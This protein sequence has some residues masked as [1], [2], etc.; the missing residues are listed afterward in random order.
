MIGRNIRSSSC[1]TSGVGTASW[2]SA[3]GSQ[4]GIAFSLFFLFFLLFSF[5]GIRLL[6]AKRADRKEER[7][8]KKNIYS[9]IPFFSFFF[10]PLQYSTSTPNLRNQG[11]EQT[12][13]GE[14]NTAG[15][16]G[17]RVKNENSTKMPKPYH[18]ERKRKNR[19]QTK[20]NQ[21]KP[22]QTSNK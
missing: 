7:K 6:T 17:A 11:D 3:V 9:F 15:G 5:E 1:C 20:P 22:N 19:S 14:K 18:Q 4:P 21:T 13:K 10:G 12:K 2:L 8:K 16:A